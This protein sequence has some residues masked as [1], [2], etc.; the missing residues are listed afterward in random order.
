MRARWATISL[1]VLSAGSFAAPVPAGPPNFVGTL[2]A[3]YTLQLS[4]E[5]GVRTA[6][7][8]VPLLA[9]LYRDLTKDGLWSVSLLGKN[10]VGGPRCAAAMACSDV[11]AGVTIVPSGDLTSHNLRAIA[12]K[13]SALRRKFALSG[14]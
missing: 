14:S 9:S 5:K 4:G 2:D 3:R 7:A 8:Q 11:Q 13:E 6:H 12:V 1:V 10:Y